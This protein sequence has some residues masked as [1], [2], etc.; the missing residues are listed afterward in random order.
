[1]GAVAPGALA[2]AFVVGSGGAATPEG[3]AGAPP[4]PGTAPAPCLQVQPQAAKRSLPEDAEA[5]DAGAMQLECPKCDD[6]LTDETIAKTTQDKKKFAMGL[7]CDCND[8]NGHY[9]DLTRRWKTNR[10]LQVWFNGMEENERKDWFKGKKAITSKLSLA[11]K[12]AQNKRLKATEADEKKKG[13]RPGKLLHWKPW[14]IVKRDLMIEGYTAESAKQE[15]RRRCMD[16]SYK[17]KLIDNMWH[18]AEY[19]GVMDES[20]TEVGHAVRMEA[21]HSCDDTEA[22]G[23]AADV[24]DSFIARAPPAPSMAEFAPQDADGHVP[25]QFVEGAVMDMP[26]DQPWLAMDGTMVGMEEVERLQKNLNDFMMQ[27]EV[28]AEGVEVPAEEKSTDHA[29]L[30][31][32]M[33]QQI[34]KAKLTMQGQA[35]A[36]EL[37]SDQLLT[38]VRTVEFPSVQRHG[39]RWRIRSKTWSRRP[40]RCTSVSARGPMM[41]RSRWATSLQAS[42]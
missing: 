39:Q 21:V 28:E 12:R 31:L 24:L 36:L 8:C 33:R 30:L 37:S 25:E 40:L 10:S 15:W 2:E 22:A 27:C 32:K 35:E 13:E 7:P 29:D 38:H 6:P 20:F 4:T 18:M 11:Q 41:P 9:K 14:H 42:P 17:M 3:A 26:L 34:A 16:K 1:L 23:R 19:Q 5:R